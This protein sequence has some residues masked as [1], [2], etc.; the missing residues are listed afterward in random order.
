MVELI[1]K[2]HKEFIV[3]KSYEIIDPNFKSN[4]FKGYTPTQTEII[5]YIQTNNFDSVDIKYDNRYIMRYFIMK[6]NKIKLIPL[7][8]NSA[9]LIRLLGLKK[10]ENYLFELELDIEINIIYL[11]D[12][13][14]ELN[15]LINSDN[16]V[17]NHTVLHQQTHPMDYCTICANK[18]ELKG[19]DKINCCLSKKCK[20]KSKHVVMNNKITDLYKK[21]PY[22][23][24]ILIDILIVGTTHPKEEK[25][26]KPLP[27]IKN[28]SNLAELKKL[29]ESEITNIS[30]NNMSKCSD[31]IELIRIIGSNAYAIILNAISDNYFSLSTIERFQTD[32][33]NR[34]NKN[35]DVFDSKNVK[36]IGLN[37]SYEIESKFKKE[38][39]LFHGI[40]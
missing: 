35:E 13:L 1:I 5:Q 4:N 37:Y 40:L 24:E 16:L 28:I 11:P 29:I 27:L 3:E 23:C 32:V 12:I 33:F 38:H 6:N 10:I 25:I 39:F 19:L 20:I 8:Y 31:D 17:K 2:Y 34:I 36:F 21:D 15:V 14:I 26:F 7:E 22:L 9:H 30:I 18:L